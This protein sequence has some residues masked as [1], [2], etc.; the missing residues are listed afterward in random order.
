MRRLAFP[1]AHRLERRRPSLR[2]A[3]DVG[4]PALTGAGRSKKAGPETGPAFLAAFRVR[5]YRA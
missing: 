3:A 1:A 4:L 2:G 5:D